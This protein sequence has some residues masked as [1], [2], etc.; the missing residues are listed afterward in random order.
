MNEQD[1][2]S[3]PRNPAIKEKIKK[4]GQKTYW[5]RLYVGVNPLTGKKATTSRRGFS[6][7]READKAYR[8]LQGIVEAGK[9]DWQKE[10]V[11]TYREVYTVW[12]DKSYSKTVQASTLGKTEQIFNKH[13]LPKIGDLLIKKITPGIMQDAVDAWAPT[14]TKYKTVINYADK[15]FKYAKIKSWI[16]DDPMEHVEIPKLGKPRTPKAD[17]FFETPE[18]KR[19]LNFI[20]GNTDAKE[21]NGL[22]NYEQVAFFRT[23]AFTGMRKG[24]MLALQWKD[25]SFSKLT[26]D[27]SKTLAVDRKNKLCIQPP[28]WRS[29]RVI[30]VEPKTMRMLGAWKSLQARERG[31]DNIA[32]PEQLVFPNENNRWRNLAKPNLWLNDL[33]DLGTQNYQ[34]AYN[35]THDKKFKEFVHR[36]TPHGFR[37]THT[38]WLFETDSN[39]EPKEV[40][41]RLGHKD[42]KVTMEVYTHVTRQRRDAMRQS[43]IKNTDF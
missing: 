30:D 10:T 41:E 21:N 40:M 4:N 17:N 9:W 7:P 32:N 18:L 6:T 25:V 27:I 13:I 36:I 28:K 16:K 37:H 38:T 35:A 2:F 31:F 12:L 42:T 8:I 3:Y 11:D 5:F 19:F 14:Y 20:E 26:I 22:I 39:R 43:M 15:V 24:E 23:L 34:A 29:Y 33:I 1:T